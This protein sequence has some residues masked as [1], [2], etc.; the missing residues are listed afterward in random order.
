MIRVAGGTYFERVS[1]PAWNRLFGS[2]LRAAQALAPAT[3][4]LLETVVGAR[5]EVQLDDLATTIGFSVNKHLSTQTVTFLYDHC[6]SDPR[7]L[8]RPDLIGRQR[9]HVEGAIVLCYGMLD[10]ELH[11]VGDTVIYDPQSP[12][13]PVTF[14]STG[15]SASRLAVVLNAAECEKLT[16]ISD[17]REAAAALL[18]IEDAE[19]VIVKRGLHGA[20]AVT[21][22]ADFTVPAYKAQFAWT[23]GSGDLFAASFARFWG[24]QNMNIAEA[25]DLAS[26]AVSLYAD[27]RA[28]P[29]LDPKTLVEGAT[30]PIQTRQEVR[31]YL[32]GP[33]FSMSQ[34]WLVNESRRA[35]ARL[36]AVVNSPLHD[37]GI[38]DASYVAVK[39]IELLEKSNIVFAILDGLDA[40]TLF[41]VGYARRMGLPVIALAQSVPDE[42]LKMVRGSGCEVIEDFATA[43]SSVFINP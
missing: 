3:E 17:P 11:V 42:P 12:D 32:A 33:F 19:V 4:I 6:L 39:D 8:P 20:L 38:G 41:E 1:E 10:G 30:T 2:G 23:L 26:R 22:H 40:G 35:L 7:I 14:S 28:L 27:H 43:I 5:D 37:V 34:R 18:K 16:G 31:V 29:P 13:A 25:I 15:S 36:G 21:A 24:E 9:L